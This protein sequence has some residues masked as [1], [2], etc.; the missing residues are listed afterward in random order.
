MTSLPEQPEPPRLRD[1]V[2]YI[3]TTFETRVRMMIAYVARQEARQAVIRKLKQEGKVRVSLMSASAITQLAKAHL[4]RNA[5]ELL[6]QAEAS[7][8]VQR[9][10]REMAHQASP[11]LPN[12]ASADASAS[13]GVDIAG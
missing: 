10:R 13:A 1:G 11:V 12:G 7:G 2:H 5:E 3:P 4:Q 6:R 8:A 9:L